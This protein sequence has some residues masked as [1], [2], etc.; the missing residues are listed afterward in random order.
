[1]HKQKPAKNVKVYLYAVKSHFTPLPLPLLI[2][3]LFF[4]SPMSCNSP[5]SQLLTLSL[6]QSLS[7][8]IYHCLYDPLTLPQTTNATPPSLPP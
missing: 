5:S 2:S 6:P 8:L 3:L 4:P 7:P 1:M